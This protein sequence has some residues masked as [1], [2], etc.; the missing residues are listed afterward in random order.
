MATTSPDN[1]WSPDAGDDYAL[2]TDLAAMAD[3]V[4]DAI[5]A[6]RVGRIGTNAER[7]ALT[8]GDLFEGLTFRTTDTRRDWVYTSGAWTQRMAP[9]ALAT[10]TATIGTTETTVNFP[11]SLFTQVPNLQLTVA[12]TPGAQVGVIFRGTGVN[13]PTTSNF[14]VRIFS[15]GGASIGG[16]VDWTAIQMTG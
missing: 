12:S 9:Y 10:G 5:N 1:I 4:Q 7:L 3:T 14:K 13:A 11:A 15:L 2:T 16:T 6:N 8:G